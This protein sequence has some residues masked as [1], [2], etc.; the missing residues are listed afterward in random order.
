MHA[1]KGAMISGLGAGKRAGAGVFVMIVIAAWMPA[2]N[3]TP[4]TRDAIVYKDGDRVQGV[5]IE[6]TNEMI[7]FKSDRF[8]E[9]RVRAAD[10]VVI[11][12]EKTAQAIAQPAT[13]TPRS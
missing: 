10:A 1:S 8:G 5:V 12:A 6:Q 11:R 2:A 7:V 13:A 4:T 9:L 3:V